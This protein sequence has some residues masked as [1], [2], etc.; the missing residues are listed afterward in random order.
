MLVQN[1]TKSCKKDRWTHKRTSSSFTGENSVF[2]VDKNSEKVTEFE[3]NFAKN[4]KRA[5]T[6]I[7]RV[8]APVKASNYAASLLAFTEALAREFTVQDIV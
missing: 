4:F 7:S 5:S 6:V 8:S 2:K 3:V 1:R